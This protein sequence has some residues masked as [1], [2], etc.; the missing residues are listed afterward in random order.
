MVNLKD[1]QNDLSTSSK[2]TTI[3]SPIF[4][5][6]AVVSTSTPSVMEHELSIQKPNK[7]EDENTSY[8][9][10]TKQVSSN[11]C[12]IK[13]VSDSDK[14]NKRASKL[15]EIDKCI[16]EFE[17]YKNL[18]EIKPITQDEINNLVNQTE[19]FTTKSASHHYHQSSLPNRPLSD[20]ITG[21][22]P[23]PPPPLPSTW[24][25]KSSIKPSLKNEY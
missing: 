11:Q 2:E 3:I 8:R 12:F 20:I 6:Q 24:S 10:L 5:S 21:V 22:P 4:N 25:S 7:H 13:I 14:T 16:A 9:S 18:N 1:K 19:I 17:K 23:P 15:N